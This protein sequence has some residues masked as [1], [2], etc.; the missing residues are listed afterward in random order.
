MIATLLVVTFA[1]AAP[2]D[3]AKPTDDVSEW[4]EAARKAVA[5]KRYCDALPLFERA[6]A[7]THE[8][9]YLYNAA[10][11]ANAADDRMKAF[12]L[13]NEL[14]SSFPTFERA[15]KVEQRIQDLAPAIAKEGAGK[16]CPAA[17]AAAVCGNGVVEAGE[18]CDDGNT[19]DGD[20]CSS[21]CTLQ[22]CG[23]GHVDAGEQCDDGNTKDGDGC[24]HLCKVETPPTTTTSATPTTATTATT[25]TATT[26][27]A[28]PAAAA[29][30]AKPAGA[31]WPWLVTGTGGVVAVGGIV[32]IVVGVLP[33]IQFSVDAQRQAADQQ[34]YLAATTDTARNDAVGDATLAFARLSQERADWNGYGIPLTWIGAAAAVVGVGAGVAGVV[35]AG[36]DGPSP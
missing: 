7:K 27:N 18:Q 9:K 3:A 28:K 6:Y 16:A 15:A 19:K 21:T 5:E 26:T 32:A 29:S 25:T 14:R 22:V 4:N 30:T 17:P 12:A 11:V 10:E 24:D 20:G 36:D 1:A 33:A 2:T 13:Y 35:L 31:V 34:H 23:D 8:A